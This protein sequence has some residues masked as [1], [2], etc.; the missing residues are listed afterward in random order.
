MDRPAL[1]TASAA[2]ILAAYYFLLATQPFARTSDS[3]DRQLDQDIRDSRALF[4]AGRFAEA[5]PV[6]ARLAGQLNTQAVYH[7]RHAQILH[8]LHRPAEEA[9]AWEQ[10]MAASPTPVDAC[11]MIAEAYEQ[12]GAADR[13]LATF[14]RCAAL[15][16]LNPDFLLFLGQALLKADRK[17]EARAAFER[18]LVVDRTYPDL[19]FLLGIRKFDD[20]ERAG[21]LESFETFAQLAPQRRAEVDVWL[22][23]ARQQ[24]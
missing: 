21:A 14:E 13:A 11:P 6:T 4:D 10:M 9:Q 18:G 23:R 8:Q 1:R 19:H 7:E 5:L 22:E 17:A 20:G 3:A 12:A 16:P 2:V 24:P 15:P